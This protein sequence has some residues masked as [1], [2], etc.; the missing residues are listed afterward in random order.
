[1]AKQVRKAAAEIATIDCKLITI[2]TAAGEFGF[3][4]SNQVQVEI[5]IDEQEAVQLIVKGRLIAQKLPVSTITGHTITLSDNVFNPELIMILQ[6][7]EVLYDPVDPVDPDKIIGYRPPV[8]GSREKGE[9]F[10]LNAYTAQYD[11]S[12]QVVQY[13]RTSY[14]NCQGVPMSFNSQDNVFRAPQYTIHSAP[15]QGEHP[16]TLD[17]VNALPVLVDKDFELFPLSVTSVAGSTPG[18]TE[19]TVTPGRDMPTNQYFY[20]LSAS[21]ITLP[22]YGAPVPSGFTAWDGTSEIAVASTDNYIAI[23]EA[24]ASGRAIAG[25]TTTVVSA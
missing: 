9:V 13:E 21:A 17:Y 5:Q 16:Y 23:V 6:G 15:K 11:A 4:T 22:A 24:D 1:M 18:S 20:R 8:A 19:I 2:E 25:G 3:E 14:P 10:A 12:G 7:G